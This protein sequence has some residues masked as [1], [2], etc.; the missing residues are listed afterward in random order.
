M[1]KSL[2]IE[3]LQKL[4]HARSV[5]EE[6]AASLEG[7]LIKVISER[8]DLGYHVE[9]VKTEAINALIHPVIQYFHEFPSYFRILPVEVSLFLTE[10]V[11]IEL[12]SFLSQAVPVNEEI[13]FVGGKSLSFSHLPLRMM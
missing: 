5:Y 3:F 1:G 4:V 9:D 10:Q 12:V 7:L 8:I 2:F 6:P 13:Q 11:Q